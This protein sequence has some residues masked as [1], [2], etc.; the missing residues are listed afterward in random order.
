MQDHH[1]IKP[2]W[3]SSKKVSEYIHNFSCIIFVLIV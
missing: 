3:V 1:F 2:D